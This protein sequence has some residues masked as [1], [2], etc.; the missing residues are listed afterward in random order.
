[1]DLTAEQ[2]LSI[3]TLAGTFK[4]EQR[5]L[6]FN[7]AGQSAAA[8]LERNLPAAMRKSLQPTALAF[9]IGANRVNGLANQ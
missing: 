6:S 2:T 1:M 9:R 5:R 8:K 3:M 7:L 4:R